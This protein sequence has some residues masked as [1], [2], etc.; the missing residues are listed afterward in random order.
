MNKKITFGK[1]NEH[2]FE[3]KLSLFEEEIYILDGRTLLKKSI[4]S[5]DKK[6]EFNDIPC[7]KNGNI[8]FYKRSFCSNAGRYDGN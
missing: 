1:N 6:F 7:A 4:Y 8:I 5:N 2:I 3:V